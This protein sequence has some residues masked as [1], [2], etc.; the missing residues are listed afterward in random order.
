MAE[1][2]F[3]L[4]VTE[5]EYEEAGSKF[6]TWLDENDNPVMSGAW[7]SQVGKTNLRDIEIGMPDW[8]TVGK[9]L[10]F[11][12]SIMSEMDKGKEDEICPGVD[13]KGIWKLKEIHQAIMGNELEMK[14]GADKKKHPVFKPAIYVGK[15][16]VGVW[17][18]QEGH[19][20]GDPNAP[21]VYYPKLVSIMPA[22]T[23]ET[24]Q[25]LM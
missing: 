9:S 6:I 12:V 21:I 16:A 22:G 20:A 15:P 7:A 18:M 4:G 25:S 24:E 11:P 3:I 8:K 17:E 19:K 14:V 5:E 1:Q 23:K 13:V 10:K 2:E